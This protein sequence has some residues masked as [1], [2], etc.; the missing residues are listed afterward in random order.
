MNTTKEEIQKIDLVPIPE[1]NWW[2]GKE[3]KITHIPLN[4]WSI[5]YYSSSP[6]K[7]SW[8]DSY[9]NLNDNFIP[10]SWW[11]V[12]GKE[13]YLFLNSPIH[14][15]GV[16]SSR[17][18]EDEFLNFLLETLRE[19]TSIIFISNPWSEWEEEIIPGKYL[20]NGNNRNY[21]EPT[22]TLCSTYTNAVKSAEGMIQKDKYTKWLEKEEGTHILRWKGK[23]ILKYDCKL[24]D[25]YGTLKSKIGTEEK[26]YST[27]SGFDTLKKISFIKAFIQQKR[28][29][30][31]ELTS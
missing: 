10:W 27:S 15:I 13:V 24:E 7:Q 14:L 28:K 4:N 1:E 8:I 12:A 21:I 30:W 16:E 31:I 3:K 22:L 29:E 25:E 5:E 11:K 6:Q 19:N 23:E 26:K 9:Y 20:C 2:K 18:E 17:T